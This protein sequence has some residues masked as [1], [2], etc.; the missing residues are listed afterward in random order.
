MTV[1]DSG[2][3]SEALLRSVSRS[4]FEAA[5]QARQPVC[6]ALSREAGSRGASVA[7][8]AGAHLGWPVY[9]HELLELIAQDLNVRV[10][11]LEGI[12]ERHV[13]WM[14][15]VVER[16][17]SVPAVREATFVRHLVETMLSLAARGGCI[18]VGRGSSFVLSHAS[19]LRVRIT[20][21]LRERIDYVCA[22]TNMSRDEAERWIVRVDRER[23]RFVQEHF[24]HDPTDLEQY[25]LVLNTSHLPVADCASLIA[26]AARARC[27]AIQEAGD[28]SQAAG[29]EWRG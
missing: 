25:D 18:I 3:V 16:F 29:V 28:R 26:D 21:P 7:Q 8:A 15:E 10:R 20:C 13:S 19:T 4:R 5:P 17:C 24:Q 11:L 22:E 1:T 9:D 12:D 6:V 2:R 27:H 23:R 14:Q